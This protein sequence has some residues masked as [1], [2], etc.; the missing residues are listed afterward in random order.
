[1]AETNDLNFENSSTENLPKIEIIPK[2]IWWKK[3]DFINS[4]T[5]G[6]PFGLEDEYIIVGNEGGRVSLVS[7]NIRNTPIS[8]V[9]L[10]TKGGPIQS[11]MLQDLTGFKQLDLVSGDS[12]GNVTLFSRSQILS[13]DFV[14]SPVTCLEKY[15]DTAGEFEIIVGDA[16]GKLTSFRLHEQNWKLNLV[17]QSTSIISS[18]L[19]SNRMDPA[20]RC[21]LYTIL[22]DKFGVET[23]YLLVCDGTPFVH[24]IQNGSRV[25]SIKLPSVINTM[26]RGNFTRTPVNEKYYQVALGGD[27]GTVYILDSHERTKVFPYF[28]L[29][30]PITNLVT[31]RLENQ[32]ADSL[33]CTGHFDKC[34][35]LREGEI[36]LSIPTSDWVHCIA[37]SDLNCDGKNELIFSLLNGVIEVWT[38][39]SGDNL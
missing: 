32:G 39:V 25:L 15:C 7:P 18:G 11:L 13:R 5:I 3:Y 33:V 20:I 6:S 26:C 35:I 23:S 1:M 31:I 24:F 19:D 2:K 38:F 34:H 9:T 12:Y 10:E 28:Q 17:E 37:V 29:E 27:D 14:G 36:F 30:H 22:P 21:M 16:S 4:L 8:D